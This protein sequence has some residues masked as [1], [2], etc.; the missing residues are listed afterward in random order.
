MI[1]VKV[2]KVKT[3]PQYFPKN[4][5]IVNQWDSLYMLERLAGSRFKKVLGTGIFL[6][7]LLL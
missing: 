2:T 1:L 3:P 5:A 7:L 6:S 4:L